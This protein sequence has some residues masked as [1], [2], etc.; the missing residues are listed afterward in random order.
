[1]TRKQAGE[2]KT[3]HP[4][5]QQTSAVIVQAI[6]GKINNNE[7]SCAHAEA[8]ARDTATTLAEVGINLDL[9]EMRIGKCQLG[10]FG[11][12]PTSKSVE[13]ANIVSPEL[14]A[15]IHNALSDERLPCAAAWTIAASLGIPRMAVA[16]ACETMKIKIKPCQLG[17]F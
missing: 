16:E 15:A 8:I 2:Y 13:P 3:K 6:K 14:T 9:L 12:N 10:L 17:A 7:L 5:D 1:M 11:Y 4:P